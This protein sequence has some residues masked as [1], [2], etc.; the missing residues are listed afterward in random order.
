MKIKNRP[1]LYLLVLLTV[2]IL[3]KQLLW[4]GFIPM[5][6]FPDEQAHFAEVQNYA[7][8]N[9]INPARIPTTSKEIDESEKYLET[10]RD[11]F[12][13]NKYTYHQ[14]F[15][16][17]YS[18][19]KEGIYESTIKNF[20]TS[21]RHELVTDEATVYP[22]LY[23]KLAAGFYTSVIR[24]D[25]ITRVFFVRL[26]NLTFFILLTFLSYLIGKM[27]FPK[28]FLYQITLVIFVCFHPMLSFLGGG[29]NSDNLFILIFTLSI[30]QSLKVLNRGWSIVDI[31]AMFLVTWVATSTKE[32]GRLVP[33]VF[34][35][36][37]VYWI[38]G[39]KQHWKKILAL[40]LIGIVLFSIIFR[41]PITQF[42]RGE[43]FISEVPGWP[44]LFS[45][46]K[47]S[48]LNHFVST[49]KHT[50]REILP[51]YWGVYR[52]LSMTY[53]RPVHRIINW[54][55]VIAILG[56]FYALYNSHLK[57][58]GVLTKNL[59]FLIYVSGM[60]FMAIT[61]FDYLFKISHG[62]S[63]GVQGRY[64]FPTIVPH[65]ALILIGLFSLVSKISLNQR[66]IKLLGLAMIALHTYAFYFVTS[67]YFSKTSVS[68]FIVQASQYKPWLFK[69]P[70]LE[71]YSLLFISVLLLFIV[72]Y[73]RIYAKN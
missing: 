12:G 27:L 63:L 60:Y 64:F 15:N 57:K 34:L 36:P 72:N 35:Y 31:I 16:I 51:W 43:Q 11:G 9:P 28:N 25:I 56:L 26:L 32:L 29:V 22:F 48:Y 6:Q 24:S 5:W 69:S 19:T 68:L 66:L 38:V 23:Y 18:A 47:E 3:L 50:Y 2:S 44:I 62:F 49:A 14:E 67:S 52:W 53:P 30:Y 73:L 20:P 45:S 17:P 13:N 8:G 71:I 46:A 39:H 42:V 37:G 21:Y 61:T 55:L 54:I 58:R 59:W 4:V 40:S 70:F 7:E 65:M 1:Q 33:L 10:K 41:Q